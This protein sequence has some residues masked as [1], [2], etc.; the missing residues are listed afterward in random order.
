[1]LVPSTGNSIGHPRT[2]FMFLVASWDAVVCC[3]CIPVL[4]PVVLLPLVIPSAGSLRFLSAPPPFSSGTIPLEQDQ[5]AFEQH[6][7]IFGVQET[8]YHPHWIVKPRQ[9]DFA[10]GVIGDDLVGFFVELSSSFFSLVA[11]SVPPPL[12]VHDKHV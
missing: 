2:R 3:L 1:M 8:C 4:T 12:V 6:V 5:V 10:M 7:G 11:Q 9:I